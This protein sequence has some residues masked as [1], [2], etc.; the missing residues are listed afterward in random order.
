[1]NNCSGEELG[2]TRN[3]IPATHLILYAVLSIN[4][5][6]CPTNEMLL[7][8]RAGSPFQI[9]EE[10]NGVFDLLNHKQIHKFSIQLVSVR[11][12]KHKLQGPRL[13]FK[14]PDAHTHFWSQTLSFGDQGLTKRI[15]ENLAPPSQWK[16][17]WR[18]VKNENSHSIDKILGVTRSDQRWALI[19]FYPFHLFLPVLRERPVHVRH[20][21]L[22]QAPLAWVQTGEPLQ[23]R[24]APLWPPVPSPSLSLM[25]CTRTCSLLTYTDPTSPG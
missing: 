10:G 20:A 7:E 21:N 2:S 19:T 13:P 16:N 18:E 8:R 11:S 12:S 22:N 4:K 14:K 9:P 15:P 23:D 5:C 25:A 1:M 17:Q 3:E 24:A 6:L